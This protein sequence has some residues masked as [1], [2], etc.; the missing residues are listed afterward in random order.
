MERPHRYLVLD[1]DAIL[2]GPVLERVDA[3]PEPFVVDEES[4]S[5]E[6]LRRLY[7]DVNRIR[8]FDP[9]FRYAGFVF[10]TGQLVG[11]ACVLARSDFDLV[12]DW[13]VGVPQLRHTDAFMRGEQGVLNYVVN[14]RVSE[15]SLAVARVPFMRWPKFGMDD[16]SLDVIKN[17]G[18][19]LVVH[20]AGLKRACLGDMIRGDILRY[21][22]HR[23]YRSVPG[24]FPLL[25]L[26]ILA[27]RA[28]EFKL[29]LK[30]RVRGETA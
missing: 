12:V 7:F 9:A 18:Y 13:G 2:I 8:G 19:P 11:T 6:E 3:M 21:F 28:E 10:N 27:E 17:E 4:Q 24:G 23:Y 15:G 14:R 25:W 16:I 5:E 22:E 30:R 29:S 20:W 1:S 26:R